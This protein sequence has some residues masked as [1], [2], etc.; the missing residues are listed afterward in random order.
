MDFTVESKNFRALGIGAV[1]LDVSPSAV[2]QA[3]VVSLDDAAGTALRLPSGAKGWQS[4]ALRLEHGTEVQLP[5]PQDFAVAPGD[6]LVLGCLGP[7]ASAQGGTL[8]ENAPLEVYAVRRDGSGQ[9]ADAQLF[10]FADT[11]S[12]MKRCGLA[13]PPN[14]KWKSTPQKSLQ[15]QRHY[16]CGGA[17]VL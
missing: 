14:M 5:L 8:G 2:A 10:E 6:A 7:V 9:Q 15:G 13:A 3:V 4:A 12:I 11:T 1:V 16:L 17:G